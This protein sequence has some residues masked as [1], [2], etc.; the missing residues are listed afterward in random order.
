MSILAKNLK[1]IREELDCTQSTMSG[2][3]KVGFRTFV[4]YEAGERDAP[5]SVLIKIARLANISLEKLL[6]T[7]IKPIDIAPLEKIS[8]GSNPAQIESLDFQTGYVTFKDPNCQ[9]IITVDD[10]EKR[11]LTLFRK[12]S[13]G[14]KKDCIDSL[15]QIVVTGKVVSRLSEK[16][17]IR[18]KGS[19]KLSPKRSIK[20]ESSPKSKT[21]RKLT[22]KELDKKVL[23]E[24]IDKLKL[25]TQTINKIT[26]R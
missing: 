15:E 3:L 13:S 26:V 5:V 18:R 16:V 19:R 10:S 11:I 25:V 7:S 21:T 22:R 9:A 17:G 12:M 6:T 4:R 8:R 14:L 23:Q 2:I 24:K 1:T 20:T